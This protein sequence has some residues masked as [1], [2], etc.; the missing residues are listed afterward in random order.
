MI[1]HKEGK[2]Y[3][4][5][6]GVSTNT[7]NA[8]KAMNGAE[9]RLSGGSNAL[10]CAFPFLSSAAELKY[11]RGVLPCASL[12]HTVTLGP[13]V[14]SA[15]TTQV[16]LLASD[17]SAFSI[18]SHRD[19]AGEDSLP[20]LLQLLLHIN[21]QRLKFRGFNRL[22]RVLVKFA[23]G[24]QAIFELVALWDV[25]ATV[26]ETQ[27]AGVESAQMLIS[28]FACLCQV[29]QGVNSVLLPLIATPQTDIKHPC[30]SKTIDP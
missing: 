24:G 19:G 22:T 28:I 8:G 20:H 16:T 11:K 26:E 27:N 10:R 17:G 14:H 9:R 12:Q 25:G 13:G 18:R 23:T 30:R 15:N 2:I 21:E 29:G 5:W 3:Q 4:R 7:G 1:G 6:L